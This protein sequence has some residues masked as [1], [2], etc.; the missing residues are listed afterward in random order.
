MTHCF[1]KGYT[2]KYYKTVSVSAKYEYY[3][4]SDLVEDES[5]TSEEVGV[6]V[7]SGSSSALVDSDIVSYWQGAKNSWIQLRFP[8]AVTI[9]SFCLYAIS[10]TSG[11]YSVS[12]LTIQ[13]S[14]DGSS[15]T[16]IN[17]EIKDAGTV[18]FIYVNNT[19][20]YKYFR[21]TI[22]ETRQSVAK[23]FDL[24][25]DAKRKI[26][27]GYTYETEGTAEDYDRYEDFPNFLMP[28][29]NNQKCLVK[30][31]NKDIPSAP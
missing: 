15:W 21:F 20:L 19:T 12:N 28:V 9:S 10:G 23:I 2:R 17:G 25:L 3:Y 4:S 1:V 13:G 14:N 5:A 30:I 26:A 8:N 11:Y 31:K 24:Y 16:T 18:T 6:S 27:D 7:S 22:T 29:I